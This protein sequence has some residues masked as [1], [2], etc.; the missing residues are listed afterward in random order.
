MSVADDAHVE[1]GTLDAGLVDGDAVADT[2]DA[3]VPETGAADGGTDGPTINAGHGDPTPTVLAA[4]GDDC[5][6]CATRNGC[7]D[8]ALLGGACED[9]PNPAPSACTALFADITSVTETQVCLATLN[10]IF[11]SKCAAT[12]QGETPCLCAAADP[13]SCLAGDVS[14]AGAA[15]PLYAC[16]FT[17]LGIA[18]ITTNFTNQAFGAGQANALVQCLAMSSC[19]CFASP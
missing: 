2:S 6:P 11:A 7:L 16:D 13:G 15:F 19:D 14:A 9:M 8:P 12:L 18:T 3:T 4:Q 17:P 1:T 5:L 10:T